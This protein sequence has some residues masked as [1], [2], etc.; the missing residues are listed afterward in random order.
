MTDYDFLHLFEPLK[1]QD[2]ARDMIQAREN[3]SFESFAGGADSGMDGRCVLENG[4]TVIFQAKRVE[5][6]GRSIAGIA[7]KGKHKLDALAE[8]GMKISQYIFV[9]AEDLSPDKKRQVMELRENAE[10]ELYSLLCEIAGLDEERQREIC[11]TVISRKL[12]DREEFGDLLSEWESDMYV[13]QEALEKF[14]EILKREST[15]G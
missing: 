11:G 15:A 12:L 5:H 4:E 8:Q 14:L 9:S 6:I 3:I 13:Q 2:F 7:R 10:H 1:F